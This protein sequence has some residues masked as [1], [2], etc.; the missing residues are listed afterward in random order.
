MQK[1]P[2]KVEPARKIYLPKY[3]SFKDKNPLLHPETRPY[4]FS[5]KFINWAST[6]GLAGI[7]LLGGGNVLGQVQKDSLYNPFPL[8]NARVPYQP[9]SFGTGMPE[10]LK[11]AEVRKAIMNAF[12]ESGIELDDEIWLDNGDL[13]VHLTGYNNEEQIG[14]LLIDY[15]NIYGSFKRNSS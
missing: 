11:S 2:L 14:F 3:P 13:E 9:V 12:A 15:N 5:L 1:K 10:R 7:M 4:P 6:G 8:E